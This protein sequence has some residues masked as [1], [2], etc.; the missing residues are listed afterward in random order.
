MFD[1]TGIAERRNHPKRKLLTLG[2]VHHLNRVIIQRIGKQ[3]DLKIR[4]GDIPLSAGFVKR[5]A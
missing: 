1:E 4:G 5:D 3:Q 2:Q